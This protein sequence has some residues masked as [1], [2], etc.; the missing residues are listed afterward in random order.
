[1]SLGD[2]VLVP[3]PR[4]LV[5]TGIG[6]RADECPVASQVDPSIPAQ[7]FRLDITEAHGARI[8]HRDDA[9]LRYARSLLDQLL[10]NPVGD[11]VLGVHI[12]DHPDI[13]VRGFMLDVSR[14]RVPTRD[15]LDELVDVLDL[16]RYNQLQLYIEHTFA[17]VGHRDVWADASPLTPEDLHWLDDRCHAVG[18]ELVVN[19]NC[20]GHF[21]RWLSH[22]GHAHRAESPTG[23]QLMPGLNL[24]P[25][26]LAPTPDNAEFAL[27]L[28]REQLACVR[29]RRVNIGCDETFELG[30]G[31]SAAACAERGK[32]EVYLEHVRRLVD[33]LLADGYEVQVWADVLRR[34]PGLAASLP[35]GVVPIAWLYEAPGTPEPGHEVPAWLAA[36]LHEVGIDT[37]TSGGFEANVAPLVAAGVPFWVAP[38]TG[39]W[40]SLCG[41]VANAAANQIDAVEVAR[42]HGA[43]GY[44][45]TAWGDSGHH[46]PPSV[47]YHPLVHGGAV[48]W[49]LEANRELDVT[50]VLDRHV[51]GDEAGVLGSAIDVLGRLCTR[52]GQHGFNASPLAAALFPHLPLLVTGQ[53]QPDQLDQVVDELEDLEGRLSDARPTAPSGAQA[54]AELR[55][56]A[57]LARQ[58]AWRLQGDRGPSMVDRAADLEGVIGQ[59]R[60]AW[61]GR[62]QPGG[63]DDSLA[64][65]ERTLAV[66]RAQLDG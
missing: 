16:C 1:M 42:R 26:V 64:H 32:G 54:V 6:P 10:A 41:R 52:T 33:P 46:H 17:H 63:L 14:D 23:A 40:N 49:C 57:R 9:G 2:L 25:A 11:R 61:L 35:D 47:T 22:P 51:F 38:G 65:L 3:R 50:R 53:A 18:I 4:L 19:R 21:D 8:A 62:A 29:S 24:P 43:G 55:A 28:V 58:G 5:P 36:I 56:A 45:V 12:E 20:F 37:D 39:D 60:A 7:G 34:H 44:L 13:A 27:G 15:T 66:D 30:Q 59:Q 31:V 48:A